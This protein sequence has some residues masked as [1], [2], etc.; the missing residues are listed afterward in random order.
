MKIAIAYS[1]YEKEEKVE[2]PNNYTVVLLLLV[3]GEIV[4]STLA[5]RLTDW[6]NE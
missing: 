1:I 3:V 2:E 4:C 5:C 6:F